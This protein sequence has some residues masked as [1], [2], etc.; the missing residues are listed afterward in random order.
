MNRRTEEYR[1]R[2]DAAGAQWFE[3][4]G[5]DTDATVVDTPIITGF[6]GTE[7]GYEVVRGQGL[8]IADRSE[9]D[10]LVITGKDSVTWLQ[11]LV[12]NDVFA[13][14]EPGSGQ[15]T[16]GVN[17]IG[18]TIAD[19]RVLHLMDMLIVDLEPGNLSNGFLKH[20]KQHIIMENVQLSDRSAQTC[21][22]AL[23]GKQA[24]MILEDIG[25][26]EDLPRTLHI[27][28]GTVGE[29]ASSDVILQR[30]NWTGEW[31]FELYVDREDAHRIWDTLIVQD[32]QPIGEQTMELLRM[33]AGEVRFGVE[34][35][36]KT[37]PIEADLN[38]T[39]NY[40]KGCYLGQEIIHRLDT[41]GTPSKMLRVIVP[42]DQKAAPQT[43]EQLLMGGKKI[44]KV[45][46][47][48]YSP[49]M[50]QVIATGYL[51]RGAYEPG[52]NIEIELEQG[53]VSARV[54]AIGYPLQHQQCSC[55]DTP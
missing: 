14:A 49:L 41:R 53:T 25:Q 29:L 34:Y 35:T 33:E 20:L 17:H 47:S 15:R 26:W 28:G 44:G 7:H 23:F 37:I 8:A 46:Q 9:R 11:G 43:G 13:L 6:D 38:D 30:I 2:L 27:Y 4:K 22:I 31:G 45:L 1:R 32:A 16:H 19:M 51:K 36:E 18:R 48:F 42:E 54:E 12:T 40:D 10:T 21:R 50:N 24:P 55:I 52:T 39:I 3:P 5:T